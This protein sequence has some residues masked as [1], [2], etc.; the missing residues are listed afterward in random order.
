VLKRN[1]ETHTR[2]MWTRAKESAIKQQKESTSCTMPTTGG[3]SV[4][5]TDDE[6]AFR[7]QLT[8][9]RQENDAL[10]DA[11]EEVRVFTLILSLENIIS[12]QYPL[13]IRPPLCHLL[14]FELKIGTPVTPAQGNVHANFGFP[15]LFSVF[16]LGART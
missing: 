2:T 4:M 14:S 12:A 15:I 6:T 5:N 11:L 9:L 10:K 3:T 13:I 8:Q 1:R 16:E 7:Q